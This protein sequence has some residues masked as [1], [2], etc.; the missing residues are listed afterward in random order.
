MRKWAKAGLV[1][2]S[3]LGAG[4][5]AIS[6]ALTPTVHTGHSGEAPELG[7]K[8]SFGIGTQVIKIVLPDRPRIALSTMVTGAM[9]STPRTLDV[10]IWYP[11]EARTATVAQIQY[12]HIMHIAKRPDATVS[13]SGFAIGDARPLTG[14]KFPLVVLS[15]GYG[16]WNT[17]FSN[18]AEHIASRGYVVA[19]IDHADMPA[20][21]VPSFLVSFSN[22]LLD[23]TLDQRGVIDH[24]IA[25]AR[26]GDGGFAALIDPDNVGLVG[27]SMGGYGAIATAG[28][29][30]TY[31][32][33]PLSK[34]PARARELLDTAN[35]AA[36][37]IKALVVF[38]PWGGQPESRAWDAA[39][40]AHISVPTMIFV[41]GED[42][43]V[44]YKKGVSWLFD[45]L[46][47]TDRRML[48][49][50]EARHNIVGNAFQLSGD[51]NFAAYEFLAEPVWRSDRLNTINQHFI[52]AFLDLHLKNRAEMVDYLNVPTTDSDAA[53]WQ[54]SF[55]EQLNGE[56]A[57][58]N[59]KQYWRGFQR[60][61]ATGMTLYHAKRGEAGNVGQ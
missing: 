40:L 31:A 18:L 55:A 58:P 53:D 57:G 9:T 59:E 15:H 24:L 56:W 11:A 36:A 32:H 46:T 27:Y 8:G 42:D 44:N 37:P 14:Q 38:S 6:Y 10:R 1:G 39:A 5:A 45:G 30:Y 22:V 13:S 47:G 51:N 17:Q 28:A 21:S 43:V 34:L 26:K 16:G 52:T 49:Y 33:Y 35:H 29:S 60:R 12:D 20:D 2:I 48:V 54:V 19:S 23:R 50:R 61:W 25:I 4:V 7:R 41:G 3:L